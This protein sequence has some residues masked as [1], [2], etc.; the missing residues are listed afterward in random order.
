MTDYRLH[1]PADQQAFYQLYLYAF[2]GEDTAERR[3]FFDLRYAHGWIYGI[4]SEDRL[5]SG[6]YSL[7]FTVNFHG[8]DYKM[9]GIGDVMSAPEHAGA[10]GAGTLLQASLE[11]MAARGV[12]LAYLAPFSYEYY[13]RFGYEQVFNNIVY[14]MPNTSVRTIRA[15]NWGGSVVRMPM[16]QALPELIPYYANR[17]QNLRGGLVRE[18][19]WWQYLVLKRHWDVALYHDEAGVLAGYLLYD[20]AGTTITSEEFVADT[21]AAFAHLMAFFTNHRNT[22]QTLAFKAPNPTYAGDWLPN[23][24]EATTTI[25]PYMMARI[26]DLDDFLRRYPYQTKTLA[27]VSWTV[28][29]ANLPANAGRWTLAIENGQATVTHDPAVND[30][31]AD[32]TIQQLTKAL[33]GATR[34]KT[35]QETGQATVGDALGLDAALV[36]ERPEFID[37]F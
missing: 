30:D 13:R 32:L 11:E 36:H 33:F 16:E 27:P 7:P 18:D 2:N 24:D 19:W 22:F 28:A 17:A 3:A 4:K 5:V 31:A 25:Q 9:N 26:V 21:P 10:G 35:L 23:P 6:L 15:K 20:R 8:V 1:T 14:A 34:L 12:T 29:D 37:Y